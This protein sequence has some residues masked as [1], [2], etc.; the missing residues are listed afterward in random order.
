VG[1][2]AGY[3]DAITGE[4]LSMALVSAE[5]LGALLPSILSLG[6]TPRSLGPYERAASREFLRYSA[7]CR[8]VLAL[9]RRPRLRHQVFAVLRRAPV[10]LDRVLG[11]AM[12]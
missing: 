10:L 4:G 6:A 8:S 11:L 9:A 7:L 2:A 5:R 12:A 3:V 1:D